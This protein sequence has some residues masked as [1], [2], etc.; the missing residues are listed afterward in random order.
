MNE[1]SMSVLLSFYVY[2][3]HTPLS[4]ATG[5]EAASGLSVL[6]STEADFELSVLFDDPDLAMEAVS[7]L[8]V[9]PAMVKKVDFEL[10]VPSVGSTMAK[11]ADC[12]LSAPSANSLS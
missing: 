12:K 2:W 7:E 3:R 4:S 1:M 6:L 10:S 8:F 11:D 5:I 9:L